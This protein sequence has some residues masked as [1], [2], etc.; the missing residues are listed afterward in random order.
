LGAEQL[1]LS[2]ASH[3]AEQLEVV[4]DATRLRE[5]SSYAFD[6]STLHLQSDARA[7]VFHD[8][9]YAPK[10]RS[11]AAGSGRAVAP[12]DGT[13]IAVLVEPGSAVEA[14]QTLAVVEA[15]KL[16]LRVSADVPG[17]VARVH[18]QRGTQVKAGQLLME[19]D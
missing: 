2:L 1:T 8:R 16:E 9:S 10:Q 3:D 13:L 18:A 7:F 17:L 15:M 6:G 4:V 19:L 11:A 12:M 14:G 5:R